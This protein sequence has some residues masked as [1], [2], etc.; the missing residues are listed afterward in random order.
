MK[1]TIEMAPRAA[2]AFKKLSQKAQRVIR[3]IIYS[4]AD[5]PMPDGAIPLTNR[6]NIIRYRKGDYRIVY[7]IKKKELV[8]LVL[9]VGDRKDVYRNIMKLKY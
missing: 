5:E 2:K 6:K 9:K 7:T 4:L 3:D 8:V 1:Y